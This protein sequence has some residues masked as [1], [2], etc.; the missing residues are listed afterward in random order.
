MLSGESPIPRPPAPLPTH[1][2]FLALAFHCTEAYKFA[3][4]RASPPSD[5]RVGHLL[6]HMQLETR[7]PE[8]LGSSYCCSTYRVVDPFSSL[9]TF[10]SSSIRGPV[11]HPIDDCEHPLLYLPGTGK[12]LHETAIS[13]S[14]QQNLAGIRN[15]VC[16][17]WLIMARISRWGSLWMVHPFVSA[18]NCVSVTPSMGILFVIL[19]R[20]E[21][22]TR[23]S[24]F[25][26]I[27]LCFA[28]VCVCVCVCVCLNWQ[29]TCLSCRGRGGGWG[30]SNLQL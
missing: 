3:R 24:S 6:L 14:F 11:F 19:R 4:P 10:S 1:S 13:G 9:G 26:L 21:V 25:L 29:S 2:H 7:A 28:C 17:W 22:S 12:A 27:F 23:W 8:V 16:I 20:N 18:P 5:C 15:S 30:L